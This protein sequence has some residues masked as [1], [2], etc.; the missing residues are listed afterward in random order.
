MQ[1]FETL[2]SYILARL[3]RITFKLSNFTN[4]KAHF[5]LVSRIFPNWSMS[6]VEKSRER[7]YIAM[8]EK[9]NY[10]NASVEFIYCKE[11][12]VP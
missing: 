8:G 1:I 12:S 11:I 6:K 2:K 4:V 7:V 5:P 3:K 10:S 9:I